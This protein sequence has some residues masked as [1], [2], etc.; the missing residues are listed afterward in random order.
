MRWFYRTNIL[1]R[2]I[3]PAQ[4]LM[5]KTCRSLTWK[6]NAFDQWML[7]RE[8]VRFCKRKMVLIHP[9]GLKRPET[10]SFRKF[11]ALLP[12]TLDKHVYTDK[13]FSL[14]EVNR[15]HLVAFTTEK[16]TLLD[17]FSPQ[18]DWKKVVRIFCKSLLKQ[19]TLARKWFSKSSASTDIL[20]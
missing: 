11:F 13:R 20:F 14:F 1:F 12:R 6:C 10:C 19:I 4:W 5:R 7:E 2:I 17:I 8:F 18:I 3:T 15:F 9:K 16:Q